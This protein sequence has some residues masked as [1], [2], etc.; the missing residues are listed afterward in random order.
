MSTVVRKSSFL[1]FL[2]QTLNLWDESESDK[3]NQLQAELSRVF[4]SACSE[5]HL[6]IRRQIQLV[7]LWKEY[8]LKKDIACIASERGYSWYNYVEKISQKGRLLPW[9]I[10]FSSACCVNASHRFWRWGGAFHFCLCLLSWTLT[11]PPPS[12]PEHSIQSCFN[13]FPNV[14]VRIESIHILAV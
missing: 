9:L 10:P 3:S 7:L 8:I 6:A 14:Q 4:N 1:Y 12:F 2:Y 5:D 11:S 13:C